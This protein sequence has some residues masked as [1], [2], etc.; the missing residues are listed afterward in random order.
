MQ[1]LLFQL[2]V[3]VNKVGAHA[4]PRPTLAELL[5][6]CLNQA[7]QQ[8]FFLSQQP[9][10]KV[11]F[12]LHFY[13]TFIGRKTQEEQPCSWSILHHMLSPVNEMLNLDVQLVNIKNDMLHMWKGAL[14]LLTVT[15]LLQSRVLG[16]LC[17]RTS[18]VCYICVWLILNEVDSLLNPIIKDRFFFVAR[19]EHI[20]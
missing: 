17:P 4:L 15:L 12:F 3:E 8:Y 18:E 13:R 20:L 5:Q 14:K 1:S 10:N 6:T 7:L 19:T 2:C 16:A 9:T 11:A